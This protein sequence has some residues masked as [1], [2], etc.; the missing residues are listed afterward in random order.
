MDVAMKRSLKRKSKRCS[1]VKVHDGALSGDCADMWK[2]WRVMENSSLTFSFH[3]IHQLFN[4]ST[5]LNRTNRYFLRRLHRWVSTSAATTSRRAT[6]LP[7][8]LRTP[9]SSCLS[10]STDSWLGGLTPSST[11][12]SSRGCL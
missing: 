8:S 9:T 11:E 3:A 1:N 7:P 2:I 4:F 10:S 5:Y 12:S 6:D